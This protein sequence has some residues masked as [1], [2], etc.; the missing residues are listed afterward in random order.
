MFGFSMVKMVRQHANKL[1]RSMRL[2]LVN[3]YRPFKKVPCFLHSTLENR[4]KKRNKLPVIIEFY[5]EGDACTLGLEQVHQILSGHRKCAVHHQFTSIPFCAATITANGIEDLLNNCTHIKKIHHDREVKALLDKA[6]PSIRADVL[7]SSGV[8]GKDV[9]IAIVDTGIYPHDD[10]KGRITAFKDLVNE[11]TDAYDDNGHGTH[12]AGDAAGNGFLSDGK[13]KGPAPEANIVGVKVL[14]K[15]GSGSL[16]A[17]IAGVQWCIDNKDKYGIRIISMSLGSEATQPAAEDPVVKIVEK[18][19][20]QGLV[21]C[22]AAGNEGPDDN[23]ISSPGI[24]PKVITVGAMDDLNTVDRSDDIP[25]DFSSRGPTID[26]LTQPDLLTPGVNIVSLR[27]PGSYL[28][29]LSKSSRVDEDYCSLSGTSMATPICAGAAAL[30]LQ[31][32]PDLSPDEV[33]E[34]LLDSA[35]DWG[36]PGNTQGKGYLDVSKLI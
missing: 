9:T 32:N 31:Q 14:D 34:K 20:Q 15:M 12:C 8:T 13:Y 22:V 30:V 2:Q 16:S 19:W 1:D 11:E 24:S 33:K 26:G 35:E 21:V 29:K 5:E 6:S 3:L 18:A 28:D 4:L 25:A 27:A 10:L 23:T 7:N 36:F 17:V